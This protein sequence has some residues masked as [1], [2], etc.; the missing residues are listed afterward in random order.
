V[1]FS[2]AW[3]SHN[4]M[5]FETCPH[6][7]RVAHITLSSMVLG[8]V[9]FLVPMVTGWLADHVWDRPTAIGATLVPTL[10]GVAWLALMVQEPRDIELSRGAAPPQDAAS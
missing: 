9:L 3:V 7:S 1:A 2:A 10:L 4:N 6:D 5:L 8:P